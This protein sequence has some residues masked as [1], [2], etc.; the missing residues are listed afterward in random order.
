MFNEVVKWF[1]GRFSS[2]V[3]QQALLAGFTLSL[4]SSFSKAQASVRVL[5]GGRVAEGR[6]S[7]P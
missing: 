3:Q 2:G 1:T 7:G 4:R 6:G 5:M